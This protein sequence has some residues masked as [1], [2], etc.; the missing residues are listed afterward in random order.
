MIYSWG[1]NFKANNYLE[2]L[3]HLKI[4][5]FKEEI[6][7]YIKKLTNLKSI[8]IYF[9]DIFGKIFSSRQFYQLFYFLCDSLKFIEKINLYFEGS[10]GYSVSSYVSDR[11]W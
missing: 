5:N 4:L 1:Y 7:F 9:D 6:H 3:E 11:F 2:I 10:D 8:T